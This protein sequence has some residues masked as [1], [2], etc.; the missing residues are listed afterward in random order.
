[1]LQADLLHITMLALWLALIVTIIMKLMGKL[2]LGWLGTIWPFW[3]ICFVALLQ[4][5]SR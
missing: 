3:G 2:K 5:L 1:M 4:T